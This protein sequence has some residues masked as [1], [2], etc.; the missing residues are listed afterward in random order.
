MFTKMKHFCFG[1]YVHVFYTF[2][3]NSAQKMRKARKGKT[4]RN[5]GFKPFVRGKER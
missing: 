4:A 1:E 5:I 2:S 3:R